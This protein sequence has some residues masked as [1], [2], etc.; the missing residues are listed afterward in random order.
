MWSKNPVLHEYVGGKGP[1]RESF[2]CHHP[3]SLNRNRGDK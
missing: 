2:R 1:G 3:E